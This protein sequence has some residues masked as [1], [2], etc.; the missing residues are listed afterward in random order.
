VRDEVLA[1]LLARRDRAAELLTALEKNVITVAQLPPA[2]RTQLLAHPDAALKSRAARLFGQGAA[3]SRVA[4]LEKYRSAGSLAGDVVRGQVVF[5]QNCAA[6]HRLGGRGVEFGPDLE[7]IRGWDREKILL[8]VLDP[9]REVA[10]N[11]QV[12]TVELKDGSLLAGMITEETAGSIRLKRIGAAEETFLRQNVVR[13]TG[14]PASL[15][16][17][18][19]EGAL[20]VQDMADLLARLTAP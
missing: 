10:P 3:A 6:C 9:N 18:G 11:Y 2:R 7:T 19:L 13:V 4:A 14:S 15:M 17:E 1:V 12:Y 8:H 20:S 5:D 16:P